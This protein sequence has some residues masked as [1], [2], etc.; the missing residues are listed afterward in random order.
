[1][2]CR[3]LCDGEGD[4]RAR[5]CAVRSQSYPFPEPARSWMVPSAGA[6]TFRVSQGLAQQSC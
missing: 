6:G 3:R 4:A 5:L 1:M 2:G